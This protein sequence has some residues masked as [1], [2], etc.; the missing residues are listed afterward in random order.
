MS[1]RTAL[2]RFLA[3]RLVDNA[4]R[5]EQTRTIDAGQEAEKNTPSAETRLYK[6]QLH[7]ELR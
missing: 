3:E 7:D 1:R 5:E 4:L 6:E 2:L